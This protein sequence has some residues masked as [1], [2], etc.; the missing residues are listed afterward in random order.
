MLKCCKFCENSRRARALKILNVLYLS[1]PHFTTN[2]LFLRLATQFANG[3][4]SFLR[5]SGTRQGSKKRRG[6]VSS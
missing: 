1:F 4:R 6:A 2:D 5:K 3:W